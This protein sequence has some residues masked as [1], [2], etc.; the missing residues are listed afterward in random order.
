MHGSRR[1]T[2]AM[3]RL[4][5]QGAETSQ[6]SLSTRKYDSTGVCSVVLS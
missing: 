5:C 3:E 1:R 6:P 4:T 2:G